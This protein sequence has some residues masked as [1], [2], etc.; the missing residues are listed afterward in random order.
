MTSA[1]GNSFGQSEGGSG[2]TII[3]ESLAISVAQQSLSVVL[4]SLEVVVG[5]DEVAVEVT[6]P[7]ISVGLQKKIEVT[8]DE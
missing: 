8:L 4:S 6:N 7:S 3:V 5:S 2:E 1:W